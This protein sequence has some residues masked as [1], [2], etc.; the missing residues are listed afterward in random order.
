MSDEA[1]SMDLPKTPEELNEGAPP[2]ESPQTSAE[3]TPVTPPV[4]E[5]PPAFDPQKS[6]Q[7]LEGKL[8]AALQF[9]EN[10]KG[11]FGTAV[12]NAI[13]KRLSETGHNRQPAP[14]VQDP[15]S[16]LTFDQQDPAEQK[17]ARLAEALKL[18]QGGTSKEIQEIKGMIQGYI[19]QEREQATLRESEFLTQR[20]DSGISGAGVPASMSG[21]ARLHALSLMS[22][23]NIS[24]AQAIKQTV[25]SIN[26]YKAEALNS[27]MKEK[28]AVQDKAPR[29]SG[30]KAGAAAVEGSPKLSLDRPNELRKAVLEDLR[31]Q[32]AQ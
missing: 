24:E 14:V 23:S 21:M 13:N 10:M 8:G 9:I 1:G 5:T 7:D 19:A 3:T 4:P 11:N 12:E 6:Y 22:N 29:V 26:A 25:D 31:Q 28:K 16:G 27:F 32:G 17:L 20:L 30:S 2:A 15:L 18:S